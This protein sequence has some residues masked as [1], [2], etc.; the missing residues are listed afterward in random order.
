MQFLSATMS[1]PVDLVS[2]PTTTP[3]LK[4]APQIVVPVFVVLGVV[5]EPLLIRKAFLLYKHVAFYLI[6]NGKLSIAV[7]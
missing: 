4:I 6:K 3:S 5:M 2:A 1:P 7:A